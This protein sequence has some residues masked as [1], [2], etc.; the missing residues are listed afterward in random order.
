MRCGAVFGAT[1]FSV[2]LGDCGFAYVSERAFVCHGKAHITTNIIISRMEL[3]KDSHQH[4]IIIIGFVRQTRPV[5]TMMTGLV[6]WL[7]GWL[8]DNIVSLGLALHF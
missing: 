5:V 2:A 7:V 8:F 6:G 4:H 1:I 3:N